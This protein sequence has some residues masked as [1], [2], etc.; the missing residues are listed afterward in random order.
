MTNALLLH[1]TRN[2]A[3]DNRRKAERALNRV[4]VRNASSRERI[5]VY[6]GVSYSKF[7]TKAN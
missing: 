4:T 6:R 5:L 3:R 1:L 2:K 7:L